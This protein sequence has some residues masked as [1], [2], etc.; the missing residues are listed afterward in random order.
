M[1]PADAG[2]KHALTFP[3]GVSSIK[4][5]DMHELAITDAVVAGVREH[6]GEA[7]VT[8]VVLEI[9]RLCAVVPD[10]LRF[11]FEVCAQGT[12][13][14]GAALEIID[15]PARGTCRACGAEVTL[16]DALAALCDRCGALDLEI[17]SG[18]ELRIHSVEVS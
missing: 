4:R 18:Q 3:S 9:G 16:D 6:V 17:T 11:A 13:L 1:H 12:G 14:E 15:V 2:V 8:R 10:A 7:R 5:V